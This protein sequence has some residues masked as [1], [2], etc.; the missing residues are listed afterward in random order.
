MYALIRVGC[1]HLR[2]KGNDGY[3]PTNPAVIFAFTE[4]FDDG[5]QRRSNDGLSEVVRQDERIV[6]VRIDTWSN[7]AKNM[8]AMR[9][10]K[11]MPRRLYGIT[12]CSSAFKEAPAFGFGGDESVVAGLT[13]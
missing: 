4:M 8:Q 7:T 5:G 13:C 9:P 3:I 11:T 10:E 6:I 12:C 1:R 2:Q